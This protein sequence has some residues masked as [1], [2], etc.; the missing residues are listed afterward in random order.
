M[1]RASIR[2]RGGQ[3]FSPKGL[4]CVD[5][6]DEGVGFG[7]DDVVDVGLQLFIGRYGSFAGGGE[8]GSTGAVALDEFAAQLTFG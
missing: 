5:A 7:C 1:A 4:L 3:H 2:G 6:G 8:G